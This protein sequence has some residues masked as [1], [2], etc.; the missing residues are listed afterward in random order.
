M[1]TSLKLL[2]GLACLLLLPSAASAQATIAGTI[3]DTSGAVLPG[4]TVEATSPALI[5][6]VRSV[7]S[8][9]AGQYRIVDL[10]PGTYTLT[11]SLP[12]FASVRREGL[13]LAGSFT[14]TVNAEMRVGAIAETVTV[15]GESPIVDVQ[16]VKRQEVIAKGVLDSIPSARTPAAMAV[17]VPGVIAAS[18]LGATTQD[19]GGTMGDTMPLLVAHGGRDTDQRL[20]IDGLATNNDSGAG[21]RSG[22]L[23][24]M[25]STQEFTIDVGAAG[26]EA[27][28]GGVR[29]NIIPREGG[30]NFSGTMFL[31]G[32][33][34]SW[35][36]DNYSQDLQDRG[37]KTPDRLKHAYD[38]NPGGGGPIKRDKV[39]FYAA[40][41]KNAAH[42]YVGGLFENANQGNPNVWTYAPGDPAVHPQDFWNL[43]G[44]V[45]WQ[46][47]PTNKISGFYQKDYR[48][49][50]P[51]MFAPTAAPESSIFFIMDPQRM[52][53]LSW[54]SP[55]TNRLLLEAA[56]GSRRERWRH[57]E[58]PYHPQELIGVTEQSINLQYRGGT[59]RTTRATSLN[60][61]LNLRASVSYVT[62]TNSIKVGFDN[63][64]AWR[65]QDVF[66]LNKQNIAYR[67]NNEVPNQISEYASPTFS[68]TQNP[69]DLGVWANDQLTLGRL[70]A[71]LGVRFEYYTVTFPD[72]H[73]GP[74]VLVPTRD[75]SFPAFSWVSWKD[76][77]PRSG[78][79]YDLFGNGKTAI[80]ASIGRYMVAT[81]IGT[82]STFG[83]NGNPV[84]RMANEVTRS[85]ND[86]LYPEGDPRRQN[87]APDCD[88]LLPTAN[89]EC[90]AM[91][92][93]NFGKPTSALVYDPDTLVGWGKRPDNWETSVSVQQELIPRVSVNVGYFRRWY[94]NFTMIDNKAVSASD[95]TRFQITAPVDSRLPNGGGYVIDNL[96]DLN[97]DKVGQSD[98]FLTFSS[99]YGKQIQRWNGVD[100]SANARIS[101]GLLVQGGF[102]TGRTLTD[103]CE[104]WAKVPELDPQNP[105][106]RVVGNFLTQVKLLGSYTIPRVDVRTSAS[107]QS[108]QGPEI[109]ANYVATNA[110]IQPSLGRPLSGGAANRTV[111][112][113]NPGTMFG[114]RLYQL[115]LRFGRTM[116]SGPLRT[117]VN[118]DIYNALNTDVVLALNNAYAAW[119]QPQ[120][121]I[122]ARFFKFSVQVDF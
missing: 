104:V 47:N 81:G 20:N 87:F 102:S 122:Q 55:V 24:N 96:Y 42:N 68:R 114:E 46:V 45:T 80:K 9:G 57:G 117:T 49:Q 78:V 19:V 77:S 59:G 84:V 60:G 76:I 27:P 111:N 75:L 119:Q 16:N 34:S 69:W 66:N 4:V 70:T 65:E 113:I 82:N 64:R 109:L 86:S 30:N 97:P 48:C 112:L 25:S 51:R 11:F 23:P 103:N 15:T 118:L 108:I 28:T 73:V 93:Q 12:G 90:G 100:F 2:F 94:G 85:W 101:D 95:F 53:T 74:G 58:G 121:I 54:T 115:D 110:V 13:E 106:C 31:T 83:D 43:N 91:S 22:F 50:C 116:R 39:W 29:V 40:G 67:F 21:A 1:R 71:N 17:L 62:G 105:Y 8:D 107:F 7:V 63:R 98:R 88:L 26:P 44:R 10:R 6:K 41:R 3:R 56:V 35:Q 120:Q 32:A 36:N 92:D 79:A 61:T 38:F 52:A 5:E 14:A 37:L 72:M 33:N 18:G 99:N 89:G